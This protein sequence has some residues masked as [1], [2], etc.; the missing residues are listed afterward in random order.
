MSIIKEKDRE[1]VKQTFEKITHDVRLV[2]FT[3]ETECQL[4]E[5]TRELLGEL[6]ALSPRLKLEVHDFVAEADLAKSGTPGPGSPG[7]RAPRSRP[8]W[9]RRALRPAPDPAGRRPAPSTPS[10]RR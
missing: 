9:S 8:R 3:Q 2:Y 1:H 4:C 5:L 6:A 7:P 10:R